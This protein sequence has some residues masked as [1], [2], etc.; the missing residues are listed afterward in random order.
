MKLDCQ[1]CGKITVLSE[2]ES[3]RIRTELSRSGV[4]AAHIVECACG[5]YQFVLRLWPE[6][7]RWNLVQSK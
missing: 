1:V 7:P 4:A 2:A 6:T 5:R 3:K